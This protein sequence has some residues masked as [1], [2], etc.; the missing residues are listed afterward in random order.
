MSNDIPNFNLL[1][2]FSAVMEQG[3][4]SKAATQLGTNQSTISTSLS[5]LKKDIGQEL[6]GR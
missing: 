3:S 2:V 6:F 1:A 5:R 4:L